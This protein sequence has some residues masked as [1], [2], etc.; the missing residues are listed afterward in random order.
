MRYKKF[1]S[2]MLTTFLAFNVI[3]CNSAKK[4]SANVEMVNVEKEVKYKIG[5]DF[6]NISKGGNLACSGD[7][8]YYSFLGKLYKKNMTTNKIAN[9]SKAGY[10]ISYIN[11]INNAI[12]SIDLDENSETQIMYRDLDGKN[13]K[14]LSKEPC[15]ELLVDENYIYYVGIKDKTNNSVIKRMNLDGS[16][17]CI[18]YEPERPVAFNNFKD[19]ISMVGNY[20]ILQ[21]SDGYKVLD[22][23]SNKFKEYPMKDSYM[24]LDYGLKDR[25]L[26]INIVPI[27][28]Y[29]PN[30]PFK[31]M[32]RKINLNENRDE[33]LNDEA[34]YFQ[35][36]NDGIY[37]F[38]VAPIGE[39]DGLYKVDF[40]GKNKTLINKTD[41]RIGYKA[42]DKIYYIVNRNG[43]D[44]VDAINK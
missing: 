35:L 12:Y 43:T 32:L 30:F 19:S 25:D 23:E 11:V 38:T 13:S 41:D 14:V 31:P 1:L 27:Y 33:I 29:F 2:I 10:A 6:G 15:R 5:N 28:D 26:Y 34:I 3:A 9:I 17:K 8:I 7:H 16:N 40:N 39:A 22:I 42:N 20:I 18:L 36:L 4:P 21:Y 24:I 44:I 37:Y